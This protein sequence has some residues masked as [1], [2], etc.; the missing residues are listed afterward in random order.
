MIRQLLRH[1]TANPE[2][3]AAESIANAVEAVRAADDALALAVDWTLPPMQ[4][5]TEA[6]Q[7]TLLRIC[8]YAL[9]ARAALEEATR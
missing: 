8:A 2:P 1:L 4:P 5:A 9:T 7:D 6:E 3:T